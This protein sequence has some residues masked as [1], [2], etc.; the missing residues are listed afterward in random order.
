[1]KKLFFFLVAS[2]LILSLNIGCN[3]CSNQTADSTKVSNVLSVDS[4]LVA[5][6]KWANKE[7]VIS[8]TVSHVCRH[9]GKKLF[10]FGANAEK[11]VKINAGGSFSTFD[12]K[13]EGVDLE[14]TGTVVE[15]EKIDANYLN[16][17]EADI[18]KSVADK[19]QKVCNEENKAITGQ[20]NVKGKQDSV[21]EDPYADVKEFRKK[22]A[23]SGKTY[24]SVYAI[25]CK[26]I[27]ELKK[28]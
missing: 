28:K 22:L 15:D 5:P 26:T 17:W 13:Y 2:A 21:V 4:F 3:S 1:M 25:N 10:L 24:I 18:K 23:A 14:V 19:D 27:K 12:L 7:V 9:S 16:E 6:E 11:T 20:T 8:G